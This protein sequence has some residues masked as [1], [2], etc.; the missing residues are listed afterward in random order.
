MN[1]PAVAGPANVD[2]VAAPD[3][4]V[5]Y[6]DETVRLYRSRGF[7]RDRT[8]A[9]EFRAVADAFGDRV[10]VLCPERELTYRELDQ[11]TDRIAVGLR[12][13]GLR[14]GE[15]VLFQVTNRVWTVL[16]WYGVLKAGLVPVATLAQHRRHEIV[17]IARQCEPAAHL[18]ELDYPGYD[19]RSL[20]AE[21]AREQPS[22]R[23]LLTAGVAEPMSG[24]VSIESLLARD[25]DP[26]PDHGPD[27]DRRAV[28]QV[29]DVISPESVAV[30]QLSGGTTSVPKLIP[31]LHSE[32]WYNA[33]TWAEVM[34]I[35]A[36]SCSVHLLPIVHNAGV[37][38]SWHAAHSVGATFATC[39]PDSAQFVAITSRRTVTHMLMTR[40]IAQV[41]DNE[42][43]LRRNLDGLRVITWADRAVPP[44][45]VEQ[46]ESDTC[47]VTQMFGMG[48]G[49]CMITPIDSSAE[50]R[51]QTQGTPISPLDEVRVLQPG[52]E[53][54]VAIGERGELCTRGPYTIRGYY[55][56][57]ER[58]AEAFTS[59]GFYRTGDVVAE[60][61]LDGRSYYRLEDR[62][63]D[64][65]NRG[66]EKINAEEVEQL[67]L[68]H[69]AVERAAIVAMP[70]PRLGER[71]CAFL[72]ARGGSVAPDLDAVKKFL[73]ELGVAKFKWPERIEIRDEL[74][75][76][77][78]HKINKAVLR[79][80]IRGL[81]E[82][83]RIEGRS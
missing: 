22:I 78:I 19:L 37:V 66:G 58:N 12:E 31:R 65:I 72:V 16:A 13:L 71:S 76:T 8:I 80:E 61:C 35:D 14:S 40:P 82:A 11:Q 32:Y 75:L 2:V 79:Q 69:P 53:D 49:L 55:R 1:T 62:M 77:N 7:W 70:D 34:D 24:E 43:Q 39:M 83:E 10:A 46:Y 25:N 59:D 50:A 63:N 68:R 52:T 48:E 45:I 4:T 33:K 20:A 64:L 28:A 56:A 29:Q 26:D 57:P 36:D 6:P 42:P 5:A 47:T 38:C 15:R 81:I 74:P 9:E 60:V 27:S 73:D 17:S 51:H 23:V 21:V 3:D 44:E 30:L 18:I 41:I 54:P 67:L